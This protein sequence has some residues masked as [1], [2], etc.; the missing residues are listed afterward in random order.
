MRIAA[1]DIG[2]F[3]VGGKQYRWKLIFED[4]LI[5]VEGGVASA[6][7]LIYEHG[8]DFMA[9]ATDACAQAASMITEEIPMIM[10]ALNGS[11]FTVDPDKP[12]TFVSLLAWEVTIPPL[13]HWLVTEHPEVKVIVSTGDE[14]PAGESTRQVW[15]TAC[16]YYG[17]EFHHVTAPQTTVEWYPIATKVMTYNPDVALG[18][19][20]TSMYQA[21]WDMGYDGFTITNV[22]DEAM[23]KA[24]GWDKLAEKNRFGRGF[25]V[26]AL[27]PFGGAFPEL[28]AFAEEYEDRSGMEIGMAAAW[29][30]NSLYYWTEA[31][32]EAGVV[33]DRSLEEEEYVEAI[34]RIVEVLETSTFDTLVGPMHFGLEEFAGI[35]HIAVWPVPI[36]EI[37]GDAQY[38][39]LEIYSA[40]EAEE[41]FLEA[42]GLK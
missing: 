9:Q 20:G 12:Y 39:V 37:V 5:T 15:Q 25:I 34:D 22:W 16:D 23:A 29:V 35:P 28:E 8:V 32:Q 13:V 6:N 17:L 3:E 40:Q 38:D 1:D 26:Y 30:M 31:F 42:Y 10:E 24:P 4:N 21:M 14:T 2:V 18:G 33:P 36:F 41:A 19:T 11:A 7:K 27:H